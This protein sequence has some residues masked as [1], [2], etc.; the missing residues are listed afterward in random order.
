MIFKKAKKKYEELEKVE[1]RS[2]WRDEQGD[3]GVKQIAITVGII[4]VIAVAVTLIKDTFLEQWIKQVW[5][6]FIKAI[7]DMMA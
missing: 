7:E 1:S 4:V 3:I 2:F 5:D 6:M